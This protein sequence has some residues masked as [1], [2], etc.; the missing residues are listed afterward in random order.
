M[1]NVNAA[2]THLQLIG[3]VL[4]IVIILPLFLVRSGMVGAKHP[5]PQGEQ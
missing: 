4:Y 3:W 5:T 2:P 1:F